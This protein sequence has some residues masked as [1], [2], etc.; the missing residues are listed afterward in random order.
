MLNGGMSSKITPYDTFKQIGIRQ[1]KAADGVLKQDC[2]VVL[3]GSL[4]PGSI[5]GCWKQE[6]GHI[7][8]GLRQ[9]VW[10]GRLYFSFSS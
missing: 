5:F 9:T 1:N 6:R 10:W 8:M 4:F 3:L 7:R 2:T